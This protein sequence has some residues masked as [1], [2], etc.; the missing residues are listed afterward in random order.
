MFSQLISTCNPHKYS[1]SISNPLC[2]Y[3]IIQ[4]FILL[5]HCSILHWYA[6]TKILSNGYYCILFYITYGRPLRCHFL[7]FSFA[8]FSAFCS[9]T[10][11]KYI[12][13]WKC[14][15][16]I[17]CFISCSCWSWLVLVFASF[18]RYCLSRTI[19]TKHHSEHKKKG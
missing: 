7:L 13:K 16:K 18:V 1:I 14:F 8:L 11:I 15:S 2:S 4:E 12:R 9:K 3:I 10:H 6:K 17:H 19:S 5:P